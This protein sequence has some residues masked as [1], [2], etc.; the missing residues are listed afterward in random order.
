MIESKESIRF[1]FYD[2]GV[3]V[4]SSDRYALDAIRRD[5]SFFISRS[6]RPAVS[7]EIFPEAYDYRSLPSIKPSLHSPRNFCYRQGNLLYVD[8]FGK[9]LSIID[10]EKKEHK[11]YS[12]D[13]HLRH[14]IVFL[15]I[16][17]L[18]GEYFDAHRMHR[19][20]GL[21]LEINGRGVL[22]LMPQGGGK[23]TLMLELL[24][25]K[26]VKLIS[27]DTPLINAKGD[28][29]PFPIRI[30]ID[31]SKQKPDF[32]D[33]DLQ[34]I[35]RME[36]GPKYLLDVEYFKGRLV[37]YRCKPAFIFKG[38]R[39]LGDEPRIAPA[40]KLQILDVFIANTVVGLGVYQG[41]EFLIKRSPLELLKKVGVAASRFQ[42]SLSV[43]ARAKAYTFFTGFNIKKNSETLLD[44]IT[45]N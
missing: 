8:Y 9:G 10:E 13:S 16:L 42:A 40:S 21:G 18:V 25:Q 27:E 43:I 28:I 12:V 2:F 35:R 3:E 19:V 36:F 37:D 14:E 23:T 30:G 32:P 39:C 15:T 20:H 44:F 22:I 41:I 45:K 31:A 34:L 6:T 17:S 4:I 24:K 38:V 29:L 7:I 11:V 5:F 1:S 33:A 26:G